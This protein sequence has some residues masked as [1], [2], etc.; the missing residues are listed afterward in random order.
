VTYSVFDMFKIG[1]GPSSSHTVGP[2]VAAGRFVE[3]LKQGNQ[4]DQVTHVEVRLYGSLAFTAKGHGSDTAI[5]LGLSGEVP[6]QINPDDVDGVLNT[7]RTAG[8]ISLGGDQNIAFDEN[9]DLVLE[10]GDPLPGHSNGMRFQAFSLDGEE[11]A[12][13]VYYSIGGG[14]VADDAELSAPTDVREVSEELPFAFDTAEKM[15]RFGKDNNLSIRDMM[16]ANESAL[17]NE[18]DVKAGLDKIWT[19]MRDCME[20]GMQ[21][22]G[23]LPGGLKVRR[24]AHNIHDNLRTSERK[25]AKLPHECMDW[26]SLYALAINEENASG[27]RIVTAPTNGAAGVIPAVIRYYLEFCPGADQNGVRTLL[28]VAAA[29]G[30]L[31]KTNAS[32]SGAEAGCQGEVG[33]A[34]A[35]AA[36]GLAAALDGTNEQ[37]ENAAEIGLEHHLG[38]TCDPV[39]GLVQ[40]PC[41]ERNA[42]G[43]VKAINAASLALMGDGEHFVSLDA[44]VETMRQ[45]GEDMQTKYKE[46]SQG[47]LAVNVV[48]C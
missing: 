3:F 40:V 46:T 26:I 5:L 36:A 33:S 24:R 42:M 4:L 21:A 28:L 6:D 18:A 10:F 47:G 29:I 8:S 9:T 23:I 20:R 41:I 38:M 17:Q 12:N 7:I 39:G 31:I 48:E 44:V 34:C 43:A 32:I 19:V 15:L 13:K 11:L 2:M 22:D 1:I 45:T 30:S 35:M 37:I 14:F 25:N 27:G 16:M